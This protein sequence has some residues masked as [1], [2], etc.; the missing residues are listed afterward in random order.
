MQY[1]ARLT[2]E[3][4]L[5]FEMQT[6]AH[7]I[8]EWKTMTEA[9]NEIMNDNIYQYERPT[10]VIRRFPFIRRRLMILNEDWWLDLFL[11]D[12]DDAKILAIYSIFR[13][14]NYFEEV[15]QHVI[16]PKM[17]NRDYELYKNSILNFFTTMEENDLSVKKWTDNTRNK[18]CQ[19]VM[20]I[21]KE[22]GMLKDDRLIPAYVS[23][24]VKKY[25]EDKLQG[26][27][28]ISYIS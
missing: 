22:A 24:D 15:M 14:N 4:L 10:A 13:D 6:T 19:V 8:Q 1:T 11:K 28:F 23:F 12:S 2:W 26:T 20:K 18:L 3:S 7:L 21:L 9:K 17:R 5:L 25:L 16:W 27:D